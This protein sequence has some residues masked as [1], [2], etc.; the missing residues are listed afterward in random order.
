MRELNSFTDERL[1]RRLVNVLLS[2]QIEASVADEDGSW[3][4]WVQKD[5]DRDAAR[6]VLQEFQANPEAP[7]FVAAEKAARQQRVAAERTAKS[8]QSLVI[9]V[10]DRWRGVWWKTYPATAVLTIISFLVVVICTDWKSRDRSHG[11]IPRTCNDENSVLLDSLILVKPTVGQTLKS[12]QVWRLVTPIFLHFDLLHILFNMMWLRNLGV[13]VEFVRGTRRFLVLVFLLA[14][15]SNATQLSWSGPRFGGMS[16]VVFGLIGY[17]WMKGRTQPK[18]GLGLLPDQVVWAML[19]LLLCMGGSFGPIAN[20]A[21][22]SGL[23]V[24][25]LIGGR[26]AIWAR[27]LQVLGQSGGGSS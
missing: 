10:R 2:R 6:E 14:V 22:V 21:H 23:I 27:M 15:I 5:D 19:F 26:Q 17:V 9:D 11:F 7:E 18:L 1:A 20:A 16:G 8:R 12:G 4:V 25:M 13:G 3:V 24:G